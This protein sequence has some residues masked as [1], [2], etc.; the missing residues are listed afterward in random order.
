[1]TVEKRR[2][3]A[4][5]YFFK[6][7]RV[8][9]RVV[10]EYGGSMTD[11]VVRFLARHDRLN[12]AEQLA[13][14]QSNDEEGEKYRGIETSFTSVQSQIQRVVRCWWRCPERQSVSS[15]TK[16]PVLQ[17]KDPAMIGKLRRQPLSRDEFDKLV[18][19]AE[20]GNE[21]ALSELRSLMRA[22]PETWQRIGDLTEHVRRTF[23][24]LMVQENVVA[25]ESLAIKL[26]E[27]AKELRQ[28]HQSA[29]RNLVI[30]QIVIAYL[31]LH[32]QQT[33]AAG[34][35]DR[36]AE[37]DFL[38]RR[39]ERA[40]KRFD[41]ALESLAKMDKTL[42]LVPGTAPEGNPGKANPIGGKRN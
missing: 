37:S 29:V 39:L 6:A 31:D 36:K 35:H 19:R 13:A 41:A 26:D 5:G 33:L 40:R 24:G 42:G 7:K 14:K 25:R 27:L 17:M 8:E 10:K 1:M 3:A 32:Y 21:V 12:Q 9:G 22:D 2:G 18:K 38:E 30:D 34:S 28:G 16:I 15:Q 11:P 23:L 4:S 20:I